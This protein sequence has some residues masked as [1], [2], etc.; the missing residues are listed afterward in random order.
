[1]PVPLSSFTLGEGVLYRTGTVGNTTV[2]QL[3]IPNSLVET[4]LELL[5]DAPSAGHPGRDKTLSMARAKY[6]WPILRLD[7]E[8]HIVQ[9]LFC[10]ETKRTTKTAPI[11]EYPLPGR[12]FDVIGIDLL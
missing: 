3:V 9:C 7:I 12:P 11:L 2:T 5:H 8:K 10:A 4:T 1:M 6:Y